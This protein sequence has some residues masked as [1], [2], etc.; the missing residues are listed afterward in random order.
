MY[1]FRVV[2]FAGCLLVQWS[3]AKTH[4]AHDIKQLE[5]DVATLE[6]R[7]ANDTATRR[8]V[9]DVKAAVKDIREM[10][11]Q[12]LL[13]SIL[14]SVAEARSRRLSRMSNGDSIMSRG[15]C[16]IAT[17]AISDAAIRGL[18]AC[19]NRCELSR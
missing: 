7:M 16:I 15:S 1:I 6:N 5:V 3:R 13:G 14:H 19:L 9:D 12:E 4:T 10:L 8:E 17:M 18:G 2:L 11:L